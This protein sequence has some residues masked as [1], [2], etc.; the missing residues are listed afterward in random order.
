MYL[1][2]SEKQVNHSF[3][4]VHLC[5]SLVLESGT[6]GFIK[7]VWYFLSICILWSTLRCISIRYSLKFWS[8]LS[9]N[10]FLGFSWWE[11]FSYYLIFNLYIYILFIILSYIT[12]WQQFP[13]LPQQ[14]SLP[15]PFILYFLLE[16]KSG[17]KGIS[18]EQGIASYTKAML[19]PRHTS[20]LD[21]KPCKKKRVPR[22]Q[23][24]DTPTSTFR[25]SRRTSSYTTIIYMLRPILFQS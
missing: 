10:P 6:V 8:K 11:I 9:V 25:S 4:F 12:S 24:S 21:E 23:K 2:S 22:A 7:R 5:P 15:D 1:C 20:R 13:P 17:L 14:C 19:K 3:L 18:P 16:K